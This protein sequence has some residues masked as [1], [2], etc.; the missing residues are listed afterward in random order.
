MSN[1]TTQQHDCRQRSQHLIE[2][3]SASALELTQTRL[4]RLPNL[5]LLHRRATG[6]SY[7]YRLQNP[8]GLTWI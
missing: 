6:V 7:Y 2:S 1:E 8:C 5:G 3:R 4:N